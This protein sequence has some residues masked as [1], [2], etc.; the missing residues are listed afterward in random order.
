MRKLIIL[1]SVLAALLPF[2][3]SASILNISAYI[4]NLVGYSCD[5]D[6]LTAG[7]AYS[8]TVQFTEARQLTVAIHVDSVGTASFHLEGSADGTNFGAVYDEGDSLQTTAAGDYSI[9]YPYANGHSRYRVRIVV[10]DT[11]A[12]VITFKPGDRNNALR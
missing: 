10:A 1:M 12:V 4:D 3:L 7:T 2:A 8:D 6:T 11:L 5:P 9:T